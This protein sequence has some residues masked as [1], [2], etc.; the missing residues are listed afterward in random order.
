MFLTNLRSAKSWFEVL[1]TTDRSQTA[2][3]ELSPG[4]ASGEEAEAHFESD[5]VL[6]VLEGDVLAE[7]AEER[8]NMH[9]GDVVIIPAGVHHR[10]VNRA[11][12]PA[13][14]FSVY[15]PPAYPAGTED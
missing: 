14:T 1:Q 4:Q 15:A 7:V 8:A 12:Q 6:L 9:E 10:F 11:K 2:A 3:M 13:R 5:Q